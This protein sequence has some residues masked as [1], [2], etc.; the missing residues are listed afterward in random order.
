[1]RQFTRY[2]SLKAGTQPARFLRTRRFVTVV[3]TGATGYIVGSYFYP[4]KPPVMTDLGDSEVHFNHS[5]IPDVHKENYLLTG[6]LGSHVGEPITTRDKETGKTHTS[7]TLKSE[8]V[9]HNESD[10]HPGLLAT[11]MDECLT[12]TAFPFFPTGFGVTAKM[13]LQY[14]NPIVAKPNGDVDIEVFTEPVEIK[15]RKVVVRGEARDHSGKV[16]VTG[17]VIVVEPKWAPYFAW[18]LKLKM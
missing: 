17:D 18:V 11:I 4:Q 7:V 5:K 14:I 16:I 3:A 15:G 13:S 9:K 1:M 10:T 6:I 2:Y 8:N 12:R